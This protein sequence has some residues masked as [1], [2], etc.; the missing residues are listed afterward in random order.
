M[1][2]LPIF[3]PRLLATCA[4]LAFT[5]SAGAFGA[6]AARPSP[7]DKD[8][9]EVKAS[10]GEVKLGERINQAPDV[11][12]KLQLA[13]EFVKKYPKSSYRQQMAEYVAAQLETVP[14]PAQKLTL[15][16]KY[17]SVFTGPGE[18]DRMTPF[19][20]DLYVSNN[21][22][23]DAYRVG[24]AWLAKNPDDSAL[25]TR[26]A[27]VGIAEAQKKN[28]KFVNQSTEYAK[29]AIALMEADKRPAAWDDAQWQ[30]FKAQW[31][32]QLHQALGLV[33]H[34]SGNEAEARTRLDKAVALGIAD[35]ITYVLLA[36][37]ADKEYGEMATKY[38]SMMPGAEQNAQLKRAL[39]KLDQVID[40]YAHA[41]ALTEGKPEH[42]P[43]REQLIQ[44]LTSYYKFRHNGS[45]DGMQQLIDK[46]KKPAV[47]PSTP[48]PSATPAAPPQ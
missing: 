12:A 25:R 47:V 44:P 22:H 14:D 21:R 2:F 26:L 5:I 8:K 46:Y 40:L 15:T 42:Q 48:A 17:V 38:K 11:S 43:L 23:D 35:P 24:G 4:L 19:L 6:A 29:Q 41:V 45:T 1:R 13:E 27:L 9:K 36:D 3:A 18:S 33:A 32:P 34:A 10:E 16:E 28:P 39:D 31:L 30:Q 20:V 37:M 7:Q